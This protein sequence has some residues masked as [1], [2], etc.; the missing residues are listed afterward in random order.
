MVSI[1][2]KS[3][4]RD[5]LRLLCNHPDLA[6]KVTKNN[7]ITEDSA[8]EQNYAG[9]NNC[10][11][12]EAEELLALN[13]TYKKKFGFPFILAV[14]GRNVTEI[15]TLF[16]IRLKHDTKKEFKEALKQVYQIAFLRLKELFERN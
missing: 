7:K 9:L 2:A 1:V 6:Q 8:K 3:S 14:R 13:K 12:S 11:I 5:Q 10:N 16:R 4:K 15:I